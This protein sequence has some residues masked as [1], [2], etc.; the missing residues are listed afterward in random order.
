MGHHV[1]HL[2]VELVVV[3]KPA[4][5]GLGHDGTGHAVREVF[6]DAG[7]QAQHV[8]LRGLREGY[9]AAHGGRGVGQ[10][11]GLVK[12]HGVGCGQG[13]QVLAAAHGHAGAHSLVH[14]AHHG[15]GG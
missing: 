14:G 6:L 13:L 12:D 8:L 15:D 10:R 4:A 3:D 11:A 2:G 5:L 1:L 9:D 7:G